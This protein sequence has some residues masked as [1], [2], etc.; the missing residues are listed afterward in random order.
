[1]V[2]FAVGTAAAVMSSFGPA[3]CG[4]GTPA[5]DASVRITMCSQSQLVH[6]TCVVVYRLQKDAQPLVSRFS[7]SSDFFHL[8]GG[9]GGGGFDDGGGGGVRSS[10]ARSSGLMQ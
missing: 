5:P 8:A 3:Q 4:V 6:C 10:S 9:V 1:M 2:V 7:S